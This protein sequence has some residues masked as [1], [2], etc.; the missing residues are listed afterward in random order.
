MDGIDA[1]KILERLVAPLEL[2]GAQVTREDALALFHALDA[3]RKKLI[4]TETFLDARQQQGEYIHAQLLA[5]RKKR[6]EFREEIEQLQVQLGACGA[7]ALGAT[8]NVAAKGDYG[9]SPAYQDTLDLRK[10]YDE[11]QKQLEEIVKQ[12]NDKEY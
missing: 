3:C 4:A 1:A 6:D 11:S 7:A 12:I 10:K 8:K 5:C 9:W 2:V